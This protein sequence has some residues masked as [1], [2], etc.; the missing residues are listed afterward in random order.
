MTQ[1][2]PTLTIFVWPFGQLLQLT[3]PGTA[4][5]FQLLDLFSVLLSLSLLLSP[6]AR[7]KI[8][9]DPLFRPLAYFILACVVSLGAVIFSD[10]RENLPF[11]ALY[12]LRFVSYLSVY[13]AFRLERIAKYR[14]CLLLSAALF[15]AIGFLQYLVLPDVRFLKYLGYDDHY[16]R[17][18]G[19][20]LDPNYT[21]LTLAA[22]TLISPWPVLLLPL[23]GLVPTFSRAS[24]LAL[25]VGLLYLG[26]VRKKFKLLFLLLLLGVLLYLVPKPFGEGVNLLRTASISSRFENQKQALELFARHPIFG[27]GFNSL[28]LPGS[29]AIPNLASG[30]DNSL[31]FVLTTTGLFGLAAF[32]YLLRA[33][34]RST[35]E[36]T[37]RAA[38][39]AIFTHSL[40]N[41]SLFYSWILTLIFVLINLRTKKLV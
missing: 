32:L 33:V 10:S 31:L 26:V 35:K 15:L 7:R 28:K 27:V 40:F 22:F 9:A 12:L 19:S 39:V 11:A 14:R 3:P 1:L 2:L 13:F 34:W 21:G 8:I 38:L 37:S 18:I 25:A 4:L 16:F 5:R 41:N 30:V 36:N 20:F 23:L 6:T 17:L 29:E 24:F